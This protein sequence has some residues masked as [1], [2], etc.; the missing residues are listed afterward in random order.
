MMKL[1]AF[2]LPMLLLTLSCDQYV[3]KT[4]DCEV[5]QYNCSQ[6]VQSGIYTYYEYTCDEVCK[7]YP[8]SV[9]VKAK[10][11]SAADT[12]CK[13][14]LIEGR[15]PD[16]PHNADGIYIGNIHCNFLCLCEETGI[17]GIFN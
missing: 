4:Y 1:K 15:H 12:K 9:E 5:S 14:I 6:T 3:N 16:G 11:Y 17:W 13:Q 2:L 10:G 8:P 7:E